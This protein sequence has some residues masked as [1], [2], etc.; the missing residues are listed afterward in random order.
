MRYLNGHGVYSCD[1]VKWADYAEGVFDDIWGA[2]RDTMRDRGCR[3]W[4]EVRGEED[5][6]GWGICGVCSNIPSR[7][8][9]G[10]RSTFRP[11]FSFSCL[12]LSSYESYGSYDLMTLR[13]TP[14]PLL[15]ACYSLAWLLSFRLHSLPFWPSSSSFLTPMRRLRY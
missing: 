6:C 1:S 8:S 13:P 7:S 14:V 3:M 2:M 12:A 10:I 4:E 9:F 15:V 11:H 5:A